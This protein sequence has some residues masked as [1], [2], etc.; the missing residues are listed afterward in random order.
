[1][2]DNDF[3]SFSS[4]TPCR[5]PSVYF[6]SASR[7]FL[8]PFA[9]GTDVSLS[10]LCQPP[11]S[12]ALRAPLV[13]AFSSYASFA[14]ERK[15]GEVQK[16]EKNCDVDFFFFFFFSPRERER[17]KYCEGARRFFFSF[18]SFFLVSVPRFFILAPPS[19][20]PQSSGPAPCPSPP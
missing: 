9:N 6:F 2:A 1:M 17:E 7:D 3:S 12:L 16:E 20:P 19:P 5:W 8:F 11:S 15:G 14:T 4:P 18:L 13:P 10:G